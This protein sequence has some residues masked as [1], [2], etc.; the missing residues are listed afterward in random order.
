MLPLALAAALAAG[1]APPAA[2]PY[3]AIRV[4]DAATGRGV[5]LVELRTVHGVRLWTD[6]AGVAAFR[7]PGLMGRDVFF[8]ALSPGYEFP[9][10]GFGFPGRALKAVPGTSASLKIRRVNIAER[11]YRVTGAGIYRDSVLAGLPV[12]LRRPLLNGQVVG[13][14]S[15]LNALYR[16]KL[17]WV[18][19]DTNRPGYPLGNFQV[20]AATSELPGKGGLPPDRGVDLDY[21]VDERGFARQ[22]A[23]MPGSG[24]TWI[25]SLFVLPD[26]KGRPRLVASY[27]K[28]KPPLTLYARG[29]AVFDDEKGV[30]QHLADLDFAAPAHPTGHTFTQREEGVEYLYFAHPYPLTRVR[31]SLADVRRPERYETYT[32][33][34][35]GSRLDRPEIDRD[36]RGRARYAWR[37]NA[38]AV[39]PAEQAK[40]VRQGH[41]KKGEG[42]LQLRDRDTGRAVT[43]H[44]GSVYW[45]AFRRR[46]VMVLVEIGGTS[47]H[48][49]E[50]WYAEADTPTGPWVYAVKVATHPRYSFYNPKQHPA[51]DGR[52]GRL[53]YF[54]GTYSHTFS[55][56]PDATPR[57]DYNQL[58]YRL[59][60][61]DPRLALPVAVHERGGAYRIGGPGRPVF[62]A[63]DRP[64]KGSVPVFAEGGRLRVGGPAEGAAFHAL[65]AGLKEAPAA[66]APL[67]EHTAASGEG[68]V[69][70]AGGEPAPAGYRRSEKPVC[71][72]WPSPWAG[73]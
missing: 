16:G 2:S 55:G 23:V 36:D 26:E 34:K 10:D 51:F 37:R 3:F 69:Y 47:S 63:L 53:I 70:R 31:A 73:G 62:F 13:S 33:L 44:A 52:G 54:E 71:R 58:M 56:N 72:V 67:Y 66:T 5:P 46:W 9:K 65:P 18:W 7:E 59:D 40:L 1:A 20:A 30:F 57:Y 24:P 4:V 6:S 27:V 38:P 39:G 49:G 11:L 50:V 12:P 42:L 60:L 64:V 14:D 17:F 8:T 22:M 28:V 43:A 25:M 15:V 61:A 68:R 35:E 21:F 48:L 41:L 29:L 32:C 45:N 19:G